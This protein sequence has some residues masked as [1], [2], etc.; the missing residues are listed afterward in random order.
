MHGKGPKSVRGGANI[1]TQ[2]D[3]RVAMSFLVLGMASKEPVIVDDAEMIG[4]SF[5]DFSGFMQSF[6]AVIEVV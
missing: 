3:H 4:T 6:G 2:G 5:P 1:R